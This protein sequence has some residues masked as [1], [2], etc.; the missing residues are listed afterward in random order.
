MANTDDNQEIQQVSDEKI[1]FIL[2]YDEAV[3]NKYVADHPEVNPTN[4]VHCTTQEQA[5]DGISKL[6]EGTETEVVDLR[7]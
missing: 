4:V 7:L 5:D 1:V 3:V 6:A 2:A